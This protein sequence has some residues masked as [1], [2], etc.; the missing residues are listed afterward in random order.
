MAA[1][2]TAAVTSGC[3][4]GNGAVTA[5][6]T[7]SRTTR[8]ITAVA[9]IGVLGPLT[10]DGDAGALP[11][12][13]RTVLAVL[14]VH[15]GDVVSAETL[16]DA[17]WGERLPPTWPKAM[18]GCIL[19]LRKVLGPGAI[20]TRSRG[21]R[22]VVSSEEIDAHRFV[23]QLARARE[24]L[25][26]GEPDRAAYVV[27]EALELWHGRALV[28]VQEWEPGRV[29]ARRLDELRLDAEELRID[30]ALRSGRHRDV[31]AEAQT[32]V[33]EA[34]LREHRWVLLALAQYQAGR[35]GDALRTLRHAREVLVREV[36]LDP[37]PDIVTLE[38]AILRQ[39]PS[40]VAAQLPDP[41]PVC[42][43]LG[44]VPYDV[45]D[46]D[47]FFGRDADVSE[48]LRRLADNG[49]LAVVGPSGS[50]K[51]SLV[52]AGVAAALERDGRRVVIIT[53][54]ADPLDA[55]TALPARWSIAG[56]RGRPV[57]GGRHRVPRRRRAGPVLRRARRPCRDRLTSWW[58][59]APIVWA[60]WLHTRR[61]PG[62]WSAGCS[63]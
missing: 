55:L 57:R 53:P 1:S 33:A 15:R 21:Y 41:S 17:W 47:T 36:G 48:C 62:W 30:A 10:V 34:P 7:R 37:G 46:A 13:E 54:G 9:A 16:A 44:L 11:P 28:D 25:T 52:R 61:S 45:G 12:R 23:R 40:L 5:R 26:L 22:L 51:S 27:D 8:T 18:Q 60:T 38:Q 24:L 43:Y 29:E 31:L 6:L 3:C 58:R 4:G 32:R 42:P 59:C 14:A 63:C 2:S 50:G 19:Q 20:E 35:Q 56:S 49:V 39:D